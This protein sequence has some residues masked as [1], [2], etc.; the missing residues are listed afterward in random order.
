MFFSFINLKGGVGK[1]STAFQLA[2]FLHSK[3]FSVLALDLDPQANFSSLA[4]VN[5]S[6]AAFRLLLGDEPVQ[7]LISKPPHSFH[8]I[9]ASFELNAVDEVLLPSDTLYK[10]AGELRRRLEGLE[11]VYDY[12]IADT[13]PHL[14]ILALNA[15]AASDKVV[16]PVVPDAFSS[17]GLIQLS[18][19]ANLV[20]SKLNPSLKID[21]V[22]ITRYNARTRLSKSMLSIFEEVAKVLNTK[23]YE[24]KIRDSVRLTEANSA[25]LS[26][27][28]LDATS[29]IAQDYERFF[30]ELIG[31]EEE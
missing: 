27:F 10:R 29:G 30:R 28:E 9:P 18:K 23:V 13:P 1:T 31:G 8:L 14:R 20:R 25:L 4:R 6:D 24:S 12:I 11:G 19:V 22:L 3:H 2:S 5:P 21:G 26:I 16:V 17:N 15:L 7:S